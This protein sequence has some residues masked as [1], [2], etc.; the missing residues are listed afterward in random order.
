VGEAPDVSAPAPP[1]FDPHG[2]N[3]ALDGARFCPRC[4]TPA[5][6]DFPRSIACPSCGYRAYYN[7]KPVACA[8][9]TDENDRVILLKRGFDPSKDLWTFPGG[10]VDLGESVEQAAHREVDEELG[11]RIELQALVGVYSRPQER[12]V[13]VVY[14]A[15]ALGAPRRTPEAIDVRAFE[16]TEIPW[17]ELAFWSTGRALR[18]FLAIRAAAGIPAAPG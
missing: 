17:D 11:I 18:D 1:P 14:G 3:P 8:I 7:P 10:F 12:V 2:L 15:R 6:V 16:P 13:L 4:A 9:P 5:Q